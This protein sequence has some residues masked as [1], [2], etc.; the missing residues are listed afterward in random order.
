MSK[1]LADA[2]TKPEKLIDIMGKLFK[3]SISV[4]ALIDMKF[5]ENISSLRS[6]ADKRVAA[7]AKQLRK[8][9]KTRCI[10]NNVKGENSNSEKRRS[11]GAPPP[12]IVEQ[13]IEIGKVLVDDN[14]STEKTTSRKLSILQDLSSMKLTQD[15]VIESNI[16]K[17]ISKLRKMS[18]EP[19][20]SQ[21]AKALRHKWAR[22]FQT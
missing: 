22:K 8:H 13:L 18:D 4:N 16:G 21:A 7:E 20:V 17:V 11:K 9:W 5:A 15:Q 6:H 14:A 12:S 19:K 2:S 3:A 10:E 1:K